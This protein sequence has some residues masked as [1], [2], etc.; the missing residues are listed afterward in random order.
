ML[1][2]K[3]S[4]TKR[5]N[6]K[7]RSNASKNSSRRAL[8]F[9]TVETCKSPDNKKISSTDYLYNK[10][11]KLVKSKKGS[12]RKNKRNSPQLS[13]KNGSQQNSN[14]QRKV[15]ITPIS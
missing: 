2:S 13:R 10:Y 12:K 14:D 11:E 6:C 15:S 9:D 4:S 3:K 1:S 8:G 7:I 5:R